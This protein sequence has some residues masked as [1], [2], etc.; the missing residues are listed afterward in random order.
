VD[1][2]ALNTVA[3]FLP[4]YDT[5][6]L[7]KVVAKLSKPDDDGPPI[8]DVQESEE[9]VGLQRASGSTKYFDALSVLPSYVVPRKRKSNQVRRLMKLARLLTNDEI[10]EDALEKAKSELLG[11]LNAEYSRVKRS[12][13]FKEIVEDRAKIEIEAVNWEVGSEGIKDGEIVKVDI[14]SENVEDLF[15]ASGRKLKESGHGRIG[16]RDRKT[17]AVRALH[18]SRAF[19]ES[20]KGLAGKGSEVVEDICG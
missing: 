7:Q 13:R 4:H 16:A 8:I 1:N 9:V 20:R 18:R 17:G 19:A 5:K 3:L 14:A 11:V 2:E 10:D 12:K 15:E 6:G